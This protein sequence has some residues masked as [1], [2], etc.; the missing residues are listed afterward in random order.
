MEGAKTRLSVKELK[1]LIQVTRE[2]A[3]DTSQLEVLLAEVAPPKVST[4]GKERRVTERLM[5]N[6]TRFVSPEILEVEG[7]YLLTELKDMA[8][9]AGL[10]YVGTKDQLCL[11]LI[12]AGKIKK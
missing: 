7:R 10:N 12:K 6:E 3:N 8:R 9:V 11:K 5:E 4:L 1:D 2:A